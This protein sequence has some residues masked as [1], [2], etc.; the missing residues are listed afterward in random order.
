MTFEEYLESKKIESSSFRQAEPL[1][2]EN[3]EEEFNQMHIHSFTARNLYLINPIRRK[4]PIQKK[5][6]QQ[7]IN[8]PKPDKPKPLFKTKPK[9]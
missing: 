6:E 4:Y 7:K 3:W 5:E 9:F 2:W 8:P 1:R